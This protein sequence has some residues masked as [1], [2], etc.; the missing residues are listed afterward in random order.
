MATPFQVE[1][2]TEYAVGLL[3]LL[4]RIVYRTTVV[5]TNWEGDDYFA[6]IA[7]FFWTGE[8]VML[9]L[10]GQYGSITGM[11][12]E[13]ALT[14][15]DYQVERIVIGSKCLLAGWILYVTLIWCLK[16]CMLFLYR[17]LTL[18]LLQQRM[19]LITGCTC[20]VMYLV[21]IIVILTRC[22]P[23][24][25]NWQV[26]PYPGDAC[27]LNIPNYIALVITNVTTDLMIL[28][29][30][31][32]LLWSVQMPLARKIICTLWLCTGVFIIV[33]TILRCVL[34]LQDAQ[35][36]NLG[37]IW[38]IRETFVGILAVNAPVLGPW[39]AKSASAVRSRT[40]KN[41][42][43]ASGQDSDNHHIVTIGAKESTRLERLG[44]DGRARKG[45]GWTTIDNDSEERIM[46]TQNDVAVSPKR[47]D[48]E[49]GTPEIRVTTTFD[50]RGNA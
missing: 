37:T 43:K 15:T 30:P 29:I 11:T 32:P 45:L 10:I 22:M 23:F 14:L 44:K 20:V 26:Y 21:T 7:V 6:V 2:W 17:R 48:E 31:L 1:A 9:E 24:R 34:C 41:R 33:A 38:S 12:D 42:S 49:L 36:I 27:A 13:L 4:I 39:I 35:S 47:S 46:K 3:V 5:G 50:I 16:A 18:N 25:A 8:L 19:V 40:S 28:Y